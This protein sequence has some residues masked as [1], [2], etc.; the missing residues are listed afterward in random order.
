MLETL[1]RGWWLLVLRGACAVLFGI[2][3]FVWP[4][5]AG[6]VLVLLFGAYALVNGGFTLGLA[7][8]APSGTPGK[9]LLVVL[10]L[11]GVAAGV[12]TFFYPGITALS[13]LSVIAVWAIF[14]GIFEI[15]TAIKLRKELSNEWM[16]ILGGI[17]SVVFGVLVFAMPRAG[18]ISIVWLIGTYAIVYGVMLLTVAFRLRGLLS[19]ARS[20]ARLA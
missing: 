13:L 20:A 8:R 7:F 10:G 11:L 15:S 9:G 14:T 16:I 6:E 12:V 17:L 19:E 3:A 4:A 18:A 5:T 1:K 2:L